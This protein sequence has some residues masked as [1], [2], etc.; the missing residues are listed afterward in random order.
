MAATSGNEMVVLDIDASLDQI[1]SERRGRTI[2]MGS[3]STLVCLEGLGLSGQWVGV[4]S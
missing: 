1:H 2:S 3:G 4:V